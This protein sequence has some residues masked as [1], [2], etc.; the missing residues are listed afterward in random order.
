MHG[1]TGARARAP[2]GTRARAPHGA[3]IALAAIACADAGLR[4][5]LAELWA[6]RAFGQSAGL[7]LGLACALLALGASR[8]AAQGV[9]RSALAVLACLVIALGGAREVGLRRAARAP[10]AVAARAARADLALGLRWLRAGTPS[11]GSWNHPLAPQAGGVLACADAAGWIAWHARR[12]AELAPAALAA[13][14]RAAVD[15]SSALWI[16]ETSVCGE[17]PAGAPA[18]AGVLLFERAPTLAIYARTGAADSAGP[19]ARLVP[20]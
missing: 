3:W 5:W 20:R 16:A 17:A 15:P 4:A 2:T 8:L 11:A 18:G 1:S 9:P 7:A 6:R 13:P 12:R 14:G 10:E 19:A